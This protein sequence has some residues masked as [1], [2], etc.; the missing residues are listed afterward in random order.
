MMIGAFGSPNNTIRD[1][2]DFTGGASDRKWP[3]MPGSAV[4]LLT[5]PQLAFDDAAEMGI[6][7]LVPDY[8]Q[9]DFGVNPIYSMKYMDMAHN[10]GLKVKVWDTGLGTPLNFRYSVK[11]NIWDTTWARKYVRHPSFGGIHMVDEPALHHKDC[12]AKKVSKWESEFPSASVFINLHSSYGGASII[13]GKGEPGEDR[14]AYRYFVETLAK[15]LKLNPL[16]FDHYPFEAKEYHWDGL[17]KNYF[18]DLAL[19]RR[20]ASDRGVVSHSYLLSSGHWKYAKSILSIAEMRW[21]VAVHMAF[22]Y[23]SFSHYATDLGWNDYEHFFTE[24]RAKITTRTQLEN[25]RGSLW[26]TI[27]N[28]NR[29]IRKW[30]HIYMR[31]APNWIGTAFVLAENAK[32]NPWFNLIDKQDL[33]KISDLA[34]VTNITCSQDILIGSFED[35]VKNKGF[36]I[37]NAVNPMTIQNAW[38]VPAQNRLPANITIRFTQEYRY[39]QIFERGVSRVAKLEE[40]KLTIDIPPCD[41]MFVIPLRSN[42]EAIK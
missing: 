41:G 12:L 34:G 8:F 29:E 3:D 36:Y 26:Y 33:I 6:T 19:I 40:D 42:K 21:Q 7:F 5:Q 37:A 15:E 28:I 27:R 22:G 4:S 1:H 14:D 24:G 11:H 16:S 10:A 20:V 32:N 35:A 25:R 17:S 13:G 31:F 23:E 18:K 39:A 9:M 38:S 30:G 2:D